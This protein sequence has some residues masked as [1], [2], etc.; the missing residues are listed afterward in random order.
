MILIILS[1]L[2]LNM[3]IMSINIST[4]GKHDWLLIVQMVSS[5]CLGVSAVMYLIKI[6]KSK[7]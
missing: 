4:D 5:L 3:L 1:L 7:A 6:K 2:L